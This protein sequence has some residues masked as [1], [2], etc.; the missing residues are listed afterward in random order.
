MT[1][2]DVLI[3]GSGPSALAAIRQLPHGLRVL[4]LDRGHTIPNSVLDIQNRYRNAQTSNA[5]NEKNRARNLIP[6]ASKNNYRLKSYW[7]SEFPYLT[8]ELGPPYESKSRGGFTSVWGATCFP[9]TRSV[10]NNLDAATFAEYSAALSEIEKLIDVSWSGSNTNCYE[11][12]NTRNTLLCEGSMFEGNMAASGERLDLNGGHV[13]WEV[14]RLAVSKLNQKKQ[15]NPEDGCLNCGQCQNGCPFGVVWNSWF[16]F[17][18]E[19]LRLGATYLRANLISAKDLGEFVQVE[20]QD[21]EMTS[22]VMT[23]RVFLTGGPLSTSRILLRSGIV[24]S[25]HLVD[26]QTSMIL[27]LSLRKR[28]VKRKHHNVSFPDTSFLY[29]N[30]GYEVALQSYYFSP[31]IL[32]R[33]VQLPSVMNKISQIILKFLQKFLFVGL[34]YFDSSM[35]GRLELDSSGRSSFVRGNDFLQKKI[36]K[37]FRRDMKK[38]GLFFIPKLISLPVGGGYHFMGKFFPSNFWIN[39]KALEDQGMTKL[40]RLATFQ[41]AERIHLLDGSILGHLP[42]G[43]VTL[44]SMATTTTLVKRILRA[45][46]IDN[47]RIQQNH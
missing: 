46:P 43:S 39:E 36:A 41:G 26:S 6:G 10:L 27:G 32:S 35:S 2:Y 20:Y 19:V 44:S 45:N 28:L 22:S 8:S 21:T 42:T 33:L 38:F 25:L 11:P 34:L 17:E 23:K 31:Y 18:A 15:K 12:C 29:V 13:Y 24:N 16:D 9:P 4:V 1:H 30:Q 3:V 47:L 14:T 40:S 37:G 7:G 5:E